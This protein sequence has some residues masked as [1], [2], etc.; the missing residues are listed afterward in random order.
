MCFPGDQ[1]LFPHVS[2]KNIKYEVNFGQKDEAWNAPPEDQGW[3]FPA[4]I[5]LEERQA[6]P[7]RAE[8]RADC[9]VRNDHFREL[10][11]K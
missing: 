8:K 3:V 6:G 1:Y 11:R 2:T 10:D 7:A 5:P 9:E 4:Q